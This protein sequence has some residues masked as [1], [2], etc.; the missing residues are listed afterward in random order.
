[1]PST[2]RFAALALL[3]PFA[4]PSCAADAGSETPHVYVALDQQFSEKVLDGFGRKLGIAVRQRHDAESNKTVGLVTAIVEDKDHQRCSVFWNN[5]IAHTVR[6]AQQGLLEPYAS[7]NAADVPAQWRDPQDRW[8]AFA[9]RARV[10]IVNTELVP[11]EQ[12]WPKGY[13]DL[14]DPKWK[15]RCAIAAPQNG[16]TW[17]HFTA[18]WKVLGD[19]GMKAWIE[20]MQAN[21]V[22]FMSS[23]GATMRAVRDGQKAFAFTDTDDFHVASQKGFP[24]ACVFPDQ[25]EGGIGTMLIP[26]SVALVKGGPAPEQSRRLIDEIV[27]RETE[28]LLAAAD[29]AQIPLRD[30]VAPPADAAIKPRGAFREL[31]WDLEWTANNLALFHKQY[32]GLFGR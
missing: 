6:L 4:L 17:T 16:T 29:S 1:M 15:G 21:D 14:T 20:G 27:S 24:V 11:D 22:A 18:M 28:A 26:N 31:S 32:L 23:N 5:E 8:T 9:A 13:Q 25:H 12:D 10:L 7:P 19:D 3:V 2:T 30:G